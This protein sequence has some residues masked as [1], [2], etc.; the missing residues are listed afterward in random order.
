[1][2]AA[3]RTNDAGHLE[4]DGRDVVSLAEEFGAPLWVISES[5]VR[6][7]YRR[8]RDAFHRVYPATEVLYATKANPQPAI[9]AALLDEG[10]MVD[11]VTLGHLKLILRAGGTPD[12]IVFNGNSK[13]EEELR[14]ALDRQRRRHQR[15]L[16]GGDA[17][18]RRRCSRA[19]RR[20]RSRSA[21]ASPSTTR[22]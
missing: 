15:R 11:A 7:N 20:C 2:P 3:F 21:C 12:R 14:F 4:I 16:A 1:M 18:D 19:R 22:G 17:A 10:A 9:I 8:L 6:D 5:T 13:T